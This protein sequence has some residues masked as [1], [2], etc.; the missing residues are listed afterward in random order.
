MADAFKLLIN[1]DTATHAA[2][3]LKRVWSGFDDTAFLAVALPSLDGLEFKARALRLADAL[4]ATLPDDLDRA[5]GLIESALAAPLPLDDKGE[6]VGIGASLSP[7]GLAGWVVWSLGEF[8]SRRSLEDPARALACLHALTQRFTA[9]FAIRRLLHERPQ[10]CW[11]TLQRW[12]QDPSAHV[13]RLASEGSRPRLPWGLRLQALVQDPSPTEPLLRALQ[14][15]SSA[16]VRRSVANH[17]NDIA[18]DHPERVTAWVCEHLPSA[19]ARRQALLR[20]ASRT[21]IKQGHVPTLQAWGL[22]PGLQGLATLALST[23]AVRVGESVG[24][25]VNLHSHGPQAQAL[26]V[27]YAVVPDGGRGGKTFKGWRLSLA[28]AEVAVRE[29]QHPVR[30]VSTRRLYP[31]PHRVDLLVNGAV[32]AS[33]TF[34]LTP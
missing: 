8:V 28:P 25:R 5:F 11:P 13:R 3:H 30:E 23:G 18:K 10:A 2:R 6:P 17:L 16:Y 26:E 19:D 7:Q 31:G 9:E 20:H 22:S 33:A 12:A 21:L 29:K 24:L 34:T 1:A 32:L 27:D 14:D 15:D 4:Q